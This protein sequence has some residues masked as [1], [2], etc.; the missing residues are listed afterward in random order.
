[1]IIVIII[2]F[3]FIAAEFV[4]GY[5]SGSISVISDA[6]H[7]VTDLIGF[8]VS[9]AFIYYSR[10]EPTDRMTFGFHRLELVGALGNLFIIWFLAIFLIYE[11]T[12]RIIEREFVA[13]PTAMLIVG[14][15]G[16][17]VNIVMYFVLHSGSHS[18]GLMSEACDH[19][20]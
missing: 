10:M 6:F 8:V 11:A 7:L 4:G 3:V 14:A 12:V 17:V 9:F 16:L 1:L 13:E 18:H 20:H 15:G 5:I 2:S 19:N